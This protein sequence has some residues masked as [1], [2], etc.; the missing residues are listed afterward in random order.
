MVEIRK[1][2]LEA[3]AAIERAIEN[4]KPIGVLQKQ[5]DYL[6]EVFNEQF[7]SL[8]SKGRWIYEEHINSNAQTITRSRNTLFDERPIK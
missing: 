3:N 5:S 4:G 7:E 1:R 6:L 8:Y 2:F